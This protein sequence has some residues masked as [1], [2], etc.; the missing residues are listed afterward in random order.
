MPEGHVSTVNLHWVG[1]APVYRGIKVVL[2]ANPR[3]FVNNVTQITNVAPEY[4]PAGRHL[5]TASVLGVPSADD[6][7]LFARGLA[8]L[9]RMWAGDRAALAALDTYEPLAIYRIPYSQFAQPP[10]IHPTLPDNTTPIPGLYLAGEFTEAASQN[11][12]MISGEK[13]AVAVLLGR[14]TGDQ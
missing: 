8:D 2:N 7:T 5:L 14:G 11:A 10:G 4:A 12:S 1:S 3:P 6:A 9:R 13:A